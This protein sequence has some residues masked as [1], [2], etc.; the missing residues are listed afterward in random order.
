VTQSPGQP[1]PRPASPLPAALLTLAVVV[2]LGGVAQPG[3][4]QAVV[5]QARRAVIADRDGLGQIVAAF[6]NAARK[7]GQHRETQ[8][9]LQGTGTAYTPEPADTATRVALD[10]LGPQPAPLRAELTHLPP[11]SLG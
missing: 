3:Q 1:E 4:P 7:L 10:A 9:A 8:P 2:V 6:A 5:Q 11:P